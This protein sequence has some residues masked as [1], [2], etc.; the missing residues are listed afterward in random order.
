MSGPPPPWRPQDFD[1]HCET[2]GAPP[3]QLC[4]AWCD[5]GYTAADARR[6]AEL[7]DQA[8]SRPATD[9]PTRHPTK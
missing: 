7:R 3:G 1:D 8:A 6:D 9:A 5:T 4:K 2:C